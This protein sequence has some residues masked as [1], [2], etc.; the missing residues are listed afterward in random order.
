MM[1][2]NVGGWC[3]LGITY[4]MNYRSNH[5]RCSVKKK[6]VLRNYAKFTGKHQRQGLFLNK[7]SGQRKGLQLY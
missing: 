6:G 5:Q 4:Q 3:G 2:E 1:D 7:V